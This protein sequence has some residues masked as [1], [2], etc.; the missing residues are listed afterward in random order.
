MVRLLLDTNALLWLSSG[1]A[2]LGPQAAAAIEAAVSTGEAAFSSISVWETAMLV[3]KGRYALDIPV[4]RWCADLIAAGL[5]EVPLD[6]V[7][8]GQ[9]AGLADLHEDPADRMIA[10]TAM[11]LG[12][13][14]VTSDVRLIEWF[15][16]G[17]RTAALDARS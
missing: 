17:G 5:V 14:L 8:A 16:Q 1:S 10:A 9:A 6:A 13:Q 15:A 7:A 2:R 11:R 12:A 3:R 4:D